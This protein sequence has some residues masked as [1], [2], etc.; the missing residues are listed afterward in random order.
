V[1]K[2]RG[3]G[4]FQPR[5]F[6]TYINS[7]DECRNPPENCPPEDEIDKDDHPAV[8][9]VA[10]AGDYSRQEIKKEQDQEKEKPDA[11]CFHRRTSN[12]FSLSSRE[13]ENGHKT[14]A[15]AKADSNKTC[16]MIVLD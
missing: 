14:E 3:R 5:D 13:C 10:V 15:D 16:P 11:P 2:Y 9:G 7:P 8:F 6:F 12:R 4:S 1:L